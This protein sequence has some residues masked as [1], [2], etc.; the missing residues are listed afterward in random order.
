MIARVKIRLVLLCAFV[1]IA[2]SCSA[3]TRWCS[4]TGKAK[5]DTIFYPP[6]AHA[7]HI[8]GTIV[9]RMTFSPSGKVIGL[10]TI[11]GNQLI[12]TS[13]NGQ[14][15]SWTVRTDASGEELCQS[16]I[17][18][19]FVIGE[20]DA[21]EQIADPPPTIYRI[22]VQAHTIVLNVMSD[23]APTIIKSHRNWLGIFHSGKTSD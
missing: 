21:V 12:A 8:S 1:A 23:P 17:V 22:N 11:F 9:S 5:S 6:I 16:L 3:E 18:I 20:T 7:A 14:M 2:S 13:A 10:E 15:K 4:I 19:N